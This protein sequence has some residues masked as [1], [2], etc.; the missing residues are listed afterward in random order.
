MLVMVCVLELQNH[1]D[2]AG[3]RK[4][5]LE[6]NDLDAYNSE[7]HFFIKEKKEK[8]IPRLTSVVH[9]GL[10]RLCHILVLCAVSF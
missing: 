5:A 8:S 7:I 6:Q 2:E 9:I 3:D 10:S 1:N 4:E